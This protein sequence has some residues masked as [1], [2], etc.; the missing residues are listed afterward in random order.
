MNNTNILIIDDEEN[1]RK[2]LARVIELEG[3]RVYQAATIHEGM[4]LLAK[5][6]VHIVVSDVK[7][8]DGNGVDLVSRI[9]QEYPAIEIIVLTAYGTIQDGVKAIKNGAFDY[10]TKGEH[11]E[12]ILPLLSKAA[13]KALLQHK[14]Y[15]L[16]SKLQNRFGFENILGENKML[17]ERVALARKVAATSTTV[18]LLGE[19]GTGKEVFAQAIH[20]EGP[21][22]TKPFIAV[23]CS[24]FPKDLLESEL[25]GHAEGAFTGA[26]KSKKGYLEEAHEG[27]LFLDEIGE[28]N[29][30]LQAKLL[31]V[32]ESGEF[33]RVGES[34]VRHVN[35]RFIAATNRNL[36]K[37]SEAGNFR[38]DL[39]YRLSVFAISLP[40]LRER[41]DDIKTL[42][43]Y[44]INQFAR[45]TNKPVAMMSPAFLNALQQHAWKGNI[46]ELKNIIERCVILNDQPVLEADVLPYDFNLHD[47]TLTDGNFDLASAEKRHIQKILAYTKGNKTQ[48]AKLLSIGLTTLYQKIKDYNLS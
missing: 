16:E 36:E 32:L 38:Q 17:L 35:V 19:T 22:K 26:T 28:M 44:F 30:D 40:S 27:T 12:K 20:Y 14:I 18:L 41:K 29:I 43:D 45:K 46:R 48:T 13:E 3:H 47:D 1:L 7:L 10:L 24:A 23:N 5:E 34:K 31:R 8:P 9:K 6:N 4:R 2:L 11:Q 25:F 37:E 42:A 39:F 15:I 21:R 33:Y